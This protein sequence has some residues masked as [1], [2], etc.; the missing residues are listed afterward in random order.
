[1]TKIVRTFDFI[2]G[3]R[4]PAWYQTSI[5]WSWIDEGDVPEHL[6]GNNFVIEDRFTDSDGN[7]KSWLS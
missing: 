3:S 6:A 5:Q 4:G 7:T 1:M 2:D